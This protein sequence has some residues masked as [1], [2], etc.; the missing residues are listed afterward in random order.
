V[1]ASGLMEVRP[2]ERERLIVST[3]SVSRARD[4]A[5]RPPPKIFDQK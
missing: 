1:R 2:N 5:S 4:A 3:S